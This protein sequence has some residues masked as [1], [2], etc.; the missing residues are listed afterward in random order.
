MNRLP[1]QEKYRVMFTAERESNDWL[2]GK[3][4]ETNKDGQ[5]RKVY[6]PLKF[7]PRQITINTDENIATKRHSKNL[8]MEPIRCKIA[9]RNNTKCINST[10]INIRDELLGDDNDAHAINAQK[11]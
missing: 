11:L 7:T 1:S 10:F 4:D 8:G 2:V 3:V 5:N 6:E 9:L